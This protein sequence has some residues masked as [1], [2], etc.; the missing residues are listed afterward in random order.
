MFIHIHSSSCFLPIY[1]DIYLSTSSSTW[2]FP[3]EVP[4]GPS[5]WHLQVGV[6]IQLATGPPNRLAFF[7]RSCDLQGRTTLLWGMNPQKHEFG[8]SHPHSMIPC[9]LLLLWHPTAFVQR[10]LLRGPLTSWHHRPDGPHR[11]H[12]RRHHSGLENVVE[13]SGSLK[14]SIPILKHTQETS[15][16]ISIHKKCLALSKVSSSYH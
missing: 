8:F 14:C 16:Q 1:I 5:K 15:T 2:D 4:S 6:C 10:I 9:K 3:T 11:P 7:L 12:H 13:F